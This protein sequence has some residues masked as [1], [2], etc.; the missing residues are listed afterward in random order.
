MLK[1]GTRPIAALRAG[2]KKIVRAYIGNRLVFETAIRRTIT[3]L[4]DPENG[5]AVS[6]GGVY[7]EG[8]QITVNAT[9]GSG[10]RFVAW[11]ENG[12]GSE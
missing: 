4:A 2:G 1:I 12:E 5:G 10:Y 3:L 8:T 9:P 6:G 7:P 11:T